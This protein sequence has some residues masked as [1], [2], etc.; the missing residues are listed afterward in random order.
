MTTQ[1]DSTTAIAA[2]VSVT[3]RVSVAAVYT[4][5][6]VPLSR[7]RSSCRQNTHY[8]PDVM[9]EENASPM[10]AR[11]PSDVGA[12]D[13]LGLEQDLPLPASAPASLVAHYMLAS[14]PQFAPLLEPTTVDCSSKA[15]H[16]KS[17]TIDCS[18]KVKQSKTI[19]LHAF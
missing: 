19:A 2:L 16:D 15:K 4:P 7:I 12:G 9:H 18:S 1:D 5:A 8:V 10:H 6:V 11:T 3:Q 13:V 17:T 14:L